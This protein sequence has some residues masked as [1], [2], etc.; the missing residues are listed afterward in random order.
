MK[1][2]TNIDVVKDLL[3]YIG[4][5]IERDKIL[6]KTCMDLLDEAEP[7]ATPKAEPK[8]AEPKKK[9][10]VDHG[11]ICACYKAGWSI[12]KIADEVGCTDASVRL[13]LKQEGL[14]K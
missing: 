3:K 14:I 5:D 7:K 6:A 9:P 13:H 10:R 2:I 1:A 11:K 4:E 8:P 12:A